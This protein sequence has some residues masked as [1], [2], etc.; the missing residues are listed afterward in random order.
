[1]C[2]HCKTVYSGVSSNG[3]GHLQRHRDVMLEMLSLMSLVCLKP[4]SSLI[5]MVV[6]V[7]GSIMP[8]LLVSR[9]VVCLLDLIFLSILGETDAFEEYIKISHNP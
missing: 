6:C 1:V 5:L 9:S 4:W 7:I 8:R 2:K 3:T